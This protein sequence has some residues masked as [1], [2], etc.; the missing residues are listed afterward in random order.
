M[1]V[2]AHVA[3]LLK[4]DTSDVE[5]EGGIVGEL[6]QCYAAVRIPRVSSEVLGLE[7]GL[8]QGLGQGQQATATTE[9]EDGEEEKEEEGES[10]SEVPGQEP[11]L[12]E[13][14]QGLGHLLEQE[15]QGLA[16][17]FVLTCESVK[18]EEVVDASGDASSSSGNIIVQHGHPD[19][20]L[21]HH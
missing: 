15:D 13:E 18:S 21:F 12:D 8:G 2:T 11:G 20:G 6:G 16:Q 7:Q 1:D 5:V 10:E 4:K 9:V 17:V 3:K 19:R 14:G